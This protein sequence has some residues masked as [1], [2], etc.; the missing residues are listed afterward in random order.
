[1]KTLIVANWKMNPVSRKDAKKLFD[2]VK[3]GIKKAK[4]VDV[5]ICPPFVYLSSIASG[6]GGLKLGAQNVFYK[7]SG[8]FT[9]Q[10]STLMLKDLN[11]EYVIIGHSEV[12]QYLNETDQT[13]NKKIRECLNAG[14]KIILCVGEND[15]ED[16]KKVLEE[17]IK[18]ALEDVSE[19][20]LTDIIVA[21]EPIFAIGTGKNCS[22]DETKTSV[23]IIKNIILKLYPQV[24]S[25]TIKVL[26]GGSVNSQNSRDYIKQANV[27]GLLVGGA[28]LNAEEFIKIAKST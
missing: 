17:E 11:V 5:V 23:S 6:A 14:L 18:E 10:I 19:N 25:D 28:S 12:R 7:E 20:H 16:K 24:S 15:G 27:D 3:K 8:A 1:M 4:N 26:Y 21:Y 13:I 22:I 2:G 9:G